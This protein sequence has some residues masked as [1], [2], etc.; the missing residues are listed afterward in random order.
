MAEHLEAYHALYAPLFQRQDQAAS[1]RVYLTGLLSDEHRKSVERMVLKL[2]GPDRNAVRVLQQFVSECPWPDAPVWAQH[3]AG[4]TAA[5]ENRARP[6]TECRSCQVG[7]VAS[8]LL[9]DPW[10][11]RCGGL[12]RCCGHH[13]IPL[14]RDPPHAPLAHFQVAP[15]D[16]QRLQAL[17]AAPLTPQKHV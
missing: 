9:L 11:W 5:K 4:W 6:S 7:L 15:E 17:V 13:I 10:H 1:A 12:V 14:H 8:W 3:W 16:G 2:Q